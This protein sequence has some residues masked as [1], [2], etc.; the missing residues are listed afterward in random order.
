M[1]KAL[2]LHS[3]M[4]LSLQQSDYLESSRIL[5][6]S[7]TKS[8]GSK[9]S[10]SLEDSFLEVIQNQKSLGYWEANDNYYSLIKLDKGDLIKKMPK[11]VS[12]AK[13]NTEQIAI[14]IALLKWIEKYFDNKK[15]SWNLIYK[16]GVQWLK[17]F[18][19]S[20]VEI[21]KQIDFI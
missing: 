13:G 21:A 7:V 11:A 4:S 6:S 17:S 2:P 9:P 14:T 3:L 8:K 1:E 20:Y 10:K 16:K 19:L 15:E 18:G 5:T 12:D